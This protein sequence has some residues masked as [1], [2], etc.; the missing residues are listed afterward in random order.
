MP[1]RCSLAAAAARFSKKSASYE[2]DLL[3]L[4]CTLSIEI[5]TAFL[6]LTNFCLC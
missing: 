1:A 3:P 4:A 5:L 6:M 2:Y